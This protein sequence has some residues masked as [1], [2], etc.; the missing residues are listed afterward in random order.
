MSQRILCALSNSLSNNRVHMMIS[1]LGDM[2]NEKNIYS[3]A[4]FQL[5]YFF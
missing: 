3:C 1:T 2:P 5:F 4:A